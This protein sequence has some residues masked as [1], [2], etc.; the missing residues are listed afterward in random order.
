MVRRVPPGETRSGF[1]F[2][3]LEPGTK[4]FNVDVY[5]NHEDY[6]FTFFVPVAGFTP[7]HAEVDF[8]SL[9]GPDEVTSLS[10]DG[11]RQALSTLQC[12]STDETG[13]RA[14]GPFN[15]VFVGKGI[16]ITRS[17]MRAGWEETAAGSAETT[18][19][20]S[21]RYEGRR[22]DARFQRIRPGG[23]DRLELR[24]WLSP[25]R[26]DDQPVWLG[27]VGNQISRTKNDGT[28]VDYR[29]DPDL[30]AARMYL[31]QSIWYSQS[32]AQMGFTKGGIA[33]PIDAPRT[34]FTGAAYFTDGLR[35]VLWVAERPVGLD[36]TV[37][38]DWE[39][40]RFPSREG[41]R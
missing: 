25:M 20:R 3:H 2:T 41:S 7:D 13:Q 12:C 38:L 11:L 6:F 19:A 35:E 29:V 8:A 4:A 24:I 15:V 18:V 16:F 22:P 32:L 9:Y 33:A 1:V 27:Q 36:E 34:D 40:L 23:S 26:V 5:S 21:Q 39:Q 10:P 17:L 31:L 37:V 14:G 28:L 30:D